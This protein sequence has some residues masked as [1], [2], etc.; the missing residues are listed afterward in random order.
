MDALLKLGIDGWSVV[1]YSLNTLLLVAVLTKL[2]YKP[3]LRL[4]DERR[5]TI[6]RK[7]TE[8]ETLRR[9]FEEETLRQK[10]ASEETAAKLRQEL[11]AIK[12]DAA[13][14]AEALL[15]Q[16]AQEREELLART[17]AEVD[18]AKAR[19]LQEAEGEIRRTIER[20]VLHTLRTKIPPEMVEASVQS[21]WN[22]LSARP[23]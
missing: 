9:T 23:L 3:V 8:V 13:S 17:K 11:A 2:L 10:A 22:D 5:E 7:L 4:L 20:I 19:I 15:S 18:L 1:L 12:A 21:A 14:K 16:A 6:R